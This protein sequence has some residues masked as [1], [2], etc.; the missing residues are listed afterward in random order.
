MSEEKLE[1]IEETEEIETLEEKDTIISIKSDLDKLHKKHRTR[2]EAFIHSMKSFFSI[3][4]DV[5]SHGEIRERIRNNG[6]IT[7][8]NAILLIL[9]I[10]IASVGLNAGSTAAIIGAMLISPL[11]GTIM[12]IA[13]GIVS[14]DR[15]FVKGSV[16]GL[17]F[18]FL[19][20]FLVST[21]Y[22]LIT[23]IKTPT[24]EILS[25][26]SPSLFDVIIA[27]SGGIAGII[28]MTRENK[29]SNV[30]P[31][32][33]IATA[34]MPP[35]CTMGYSLANGEWKMLLGSSYLFLINVYFIFASSA[36]VL[37]ILNIPK[38]TELN[39]QRWKRL[40]ILMYVN[41]V[42]IVLPAVVLA[43]LIGLGII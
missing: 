31:G 37:S 11:M 13:Y 18:Q 39:P 7:G 38:V 4:D 12:A 28:A 3:H 6:R 2:K 1:E 32:V 22:F 24:D 21:L 9:A 30:I 27:I 10:I 33:A 40:H 23:P 29:F 34:L 5:A 35:L 20:A 25:R 17:L 15:K 36:L 26:T 8:T 41:T 19:V 42:I 14:C 16:E 43:I